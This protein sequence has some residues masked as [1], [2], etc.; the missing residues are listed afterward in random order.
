MVI[1]MGY[2]DS[3]MIKEIRE[4]EDEWNFLVIK[5]VLFYC[6]DHKDKIASMMTADIDEIANEILGNLQEIQRN[7]RR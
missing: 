6:Y 1:L 4:Q 5:Y 2:Y 7:A 3:D